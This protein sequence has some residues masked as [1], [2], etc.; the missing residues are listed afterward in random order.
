M[1]NVENLASAVLT[2]KFAGE[3]ATE[4]KTGRLSMAV[5]RA[6]PSSSGKIGASTGGGDFMMPNVGSLFGIEGND[7]S[8]IP[9]VDT[10][11]L[12]PVLYYM[13]YIRRKKLT[14][15]IRCILCHF[16]NIVSEIPSLS[17]VFKH[18]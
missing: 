8:G 9:P 15:F 17:I 6:D 11:V 3:P 7:T 5:Q 18:C 14:R 10:K 4:V 2:Q 13:I 1:E 12:T 16:R